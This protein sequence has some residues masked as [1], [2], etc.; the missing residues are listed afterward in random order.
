MLFRSA[1]SPLLFFGQLFSFRFPSFYFHFKYCVLFT[2]FIRFA[3][4]GVLYLL[5]FMKFM[6]LAQLDSYTWKSNFPRVDIFNLTMLHKEL[7]SKIWDEG[8]LWL[9]LLKVVYNLSR[10]RNLKFQHKITGRTIRECKM[11][12][13]ATS[14]TI[15]Y[16]TNKFS[17]CLPRNVYSYVN[18]SARIR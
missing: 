2:L 4:A 13:L 1:A 11:Q 6:D 14:G 7:S 8:L 17:K 3:L 16:D 18:R 15:T 9:L 10:L 12:H 5:S